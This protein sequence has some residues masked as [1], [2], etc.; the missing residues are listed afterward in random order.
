MSPGNN[1][2]DVF[3]TLNLHFLLK[4]LTFHKKSAVS[5]TSTRSHSARP[6]LNLAAMFRIGE[7]S[8]KPYWSN[9]PYIPKDRS[10][11]IVHRKK[12]NCPLTIAPASSIQP[13]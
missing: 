4:F 1:W 3:N 7:T 5:T 6:T 12:T 9:L 8:L 10:R 11:V 2:P 13:V